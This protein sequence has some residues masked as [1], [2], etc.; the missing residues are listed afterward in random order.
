MTP[1]E[2]TP[3]LS[4]SEVE[5]LSRPNDNAKPAPIDPEL[6]RRN[7]AQEQVKEARPKEILQ[8]K[9]IKIADA[10]ALEIQVISLRL[11]HLSLLRRSMKSV[12]NR[13]HCD[14]PDQRS[15]QPTPCDARTAVENWRVT[16]PSINHIVSKT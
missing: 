12:V 10:A 15:N 16:M 8:N 1:K 5:Y 9:Q 13:H 3:S 11:E 4:L 2:T 14:K 7:R 6:N